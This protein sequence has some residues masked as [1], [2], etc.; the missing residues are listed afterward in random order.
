MRNNHVRQRLQ[1]GEPSIGT[2][3]SLPS[4][5]AAEYVSTLGFDW[6][7]VDTE[8]NA[9]DI[10]TLGQMFSAMA[11][12]GVA[13]MVRIP[14]ISGENIKRV[15]DAGAWGIV[16]P[17]VN[18]RE[19]AELIVS[20]TKYPPEG[21]RSVGGSRHAMSFGTSAKEYYSHANDQILVVVQIEH[22]DGVNNADEILGVPGIDA[23]FIGPNDLAASMGLGIG[24]PLESDQP[25]LVSAIMHI[26]DTARKHGVAPGVHTSGAE[27]M[28]ARIEQGFQ[29]CALASEMKYLMGGLSE[30]I[31]QLNW[32]ASDRSQ[33]LDIT[34]SEEGTVVRY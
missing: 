3:L 9:I 31:S 5:E 29:F 10:R 27:G 14:W 8:H 21:V 13:P 26:R 11:V 6:L 30:A 34:S 4:P 33:R 22:I 24:V 12:S 17:M 7:V 19:E 20:N 28:N 16:A 18:T 25:E 1:R 23:C 15:L 2:W 32:Q